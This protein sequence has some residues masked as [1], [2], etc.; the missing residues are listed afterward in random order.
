[1]KNLIQLVVLTSITSFLTAC[2]G[3]SDGNGNDNSSSSSSSNSN[4]SS[5]SNNI[6]LNNNLS[7]LY[8]KLTLEYKFTD[9]STIYKDSVIFTAANV[10]N[11]IISNVAANSAIKY[12]SCLSIQV[13]QHQ[14]LLITYV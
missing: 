11:N 4:G 3:G 2:G 6:T 14:Y 13:T 5:A 7:D 10:N 8:G 9:T 1:M 12:I